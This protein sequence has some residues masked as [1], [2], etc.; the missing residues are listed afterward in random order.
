M[1]RFTFM[2]SVCVI[3]KE[4]SEVVFCKRCFAVLVLLN[5][6]KDHGGNEEEDGTQEVSEDETD[7][8]HSDVEEPGP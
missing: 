8:D 7:E 3:P 4:V 5:A 1:D 2:S 6:L